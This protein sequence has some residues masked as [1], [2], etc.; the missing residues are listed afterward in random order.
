MGYNTHVTGA[1]RIEPPLTW[2]EFKSSPFDG[3]DLDIKL[4]IDE[5]TVETDDGHLTRKTASALIPS[6]EESY[7][8]YHLVEHVQRAID[9]FPGH[10]FAGRLE[11]E[12]E[13]AGD[14]WR[15]VIRDGRAVEVRPRI[16]WPDDAEAGR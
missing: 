8:A 15:V 5:E 16:V 9:S 13:E 6:W 7:K 2:G 10:G 3:R 11:C 1:I 12:G 4:R 14:I